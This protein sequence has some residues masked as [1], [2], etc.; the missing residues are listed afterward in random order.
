M[1][2]LPRGTWASPCLTFSSKNIY[3]SDYHP[4][5]AISPSRSSLIVMIAGK[6]NIYE[7]TALSQRVCFTSI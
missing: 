6:E 3:F 1:S 2:V 7:Q 5:T 4:R